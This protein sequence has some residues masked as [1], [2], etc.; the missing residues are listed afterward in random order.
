MPLV[1][2]K[3]EFW[4]I[5]SDILYKLRIV[6]R[7]FRRFVM[8]S[9][10]AGRQM[11]GDFEAETDQKLSFFFVIVIEPEASVSS[12]LVMSFIYFW[13]TRALLIFS[14]R[15]PELQLFVKERK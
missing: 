10:L 15:S 8:R 9:G 4:V 14:R 3:V 5:L 6:I 1:R 2:P 7:L 13:F 12:K 11:S